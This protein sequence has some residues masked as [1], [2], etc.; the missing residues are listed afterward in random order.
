MASLTLNTSIPNGLNN[1]VANPCKLHMLFSV[2]QFCLIT[3]RLSIFPFYFS[4]AWGMRYSDRTA[5]RIS[6]RDTSR[7]ESRLQRHDDLDNIILFPEHLFIKFIS[8]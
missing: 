3:L 5:A 4:Y 8:T 6:F 2:W 7:A 1:N